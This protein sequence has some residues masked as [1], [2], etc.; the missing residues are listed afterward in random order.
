M[1][2]QGISRDGAG[3]AALAEQIGFPVALKAIAPS[4]SHKTDSGGVHL[5]LNSADAVRDAAGLMG[6]SI[7]DLDGFL[8][9]AMAKPGIELIAGVRRD[10]TFGPA[11]MLG[12]GGVWV[13]ALDDVAIRLAPLT[14]EDAN[15]MLGALRGARILDGYRGAAKVDRAAI[16][17]VL[18]ALG[19][20]ALGDPSVLEV[21]LNPVVA[22]AS[23]AEAVDARI[24]VDQPPVPPPAHLPNRADLA[25][26]LNP[27]S[28]A[29]VGA[30]SDPTKQGSR[31][32]RYLLEHGYPGRVSVV[33]RNPAPVQGL[34]PYGAITD[35]PDVPD[36]A[37]VVVPAA[38][39]EAILSECAAAGVR[40]AI[41][42]GSGFAEI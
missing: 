32:L 15:Q 3:A 5:G 20:L 14:L 19:E 38:G 27:A 29:V 28:V 2:A 26:L 10:P 12:L 4:A 16:A 36:V 13:E 8:V 17:R 40:G 11:V 7:E 23:E 18:V 9:Q 35:L 30:S 41:V 34:Q 6:A 22:G 33:N 25:R 31:L 24:L 39:V 21:D 37:C 1:P 42:F